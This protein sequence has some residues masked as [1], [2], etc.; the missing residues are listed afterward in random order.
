MQQGLPCYDDGLRC[1]TLG[2]CGPPSSSCETFSSFGKTPIVTGPTCVDDAQLLIKWTWFKNIRKLAP[3]KGYCSTQYFYWMDLE[4]TNP[5]E[6][7][8]WFF[9]LWTGRYEFSKFKLKLKRKGILFSLWPTCRIH[10]RSPTHAGTLS[11]PR[12]N[13]RT[14]LAWPGAAQ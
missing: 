10:A 7:L 3:D 5:T 14:K 11:L 4:F 2:A 13:H 12:P 1:S 6:L 9:E 8:S